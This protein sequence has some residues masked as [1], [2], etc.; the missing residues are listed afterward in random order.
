[1]AQGEFVDALKQLSVRPQTLFVTPKINHY[2][3]PLAQK[4]NITLKSSEPL[5]EIQ[6]FKN[7]MRY[8]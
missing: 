3:E 4:L 6:Q 2:L 1:M 5:V 8:Q 7:Y